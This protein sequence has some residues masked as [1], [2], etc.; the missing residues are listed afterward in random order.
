MK[1]TFIG[2]SCFLLENMA[3]DQL[4]LEPYYDSGD[5]ALGIKFPTD[6]QADVFL[7]SHPDEDH[8]YLRHSMLRQRK[9]ENNLDDRSDTDIF[10]GLDLKGTL[11]REYNGDNCIAFHFTIDGIRC[12]H[13]ADNAHLLS[14]R[15]LEEI[16]TVDIVFATMPKGEHNVAVDVIKQLNP[17]IA[18]PSHYIPVC[19]DDEQ[20]SHEQVVNEIDKFFTA[21]WMTGR[22]RDS[23]KTHEV[24]VTLFENAIGL[25]RDFD[26]YS[27]IADT[28]FE[29]TKDSLPE[30]TQIK[31]FRDCVGRQIP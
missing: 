11:V 10:P 25:K 26:N 23:A 27:E 12:L 2:L 28:S 31:V 18:I 14:E 17:K 15:Q 8:S 29:I 16:G 30:T 6:L 5:F 1:I 4:L 21:E 13:L 24:F 9:N 20:P 22:H 19:K 3:G 7:V